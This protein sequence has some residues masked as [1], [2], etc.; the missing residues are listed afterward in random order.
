MFFDNIYAVITNQKMY[1]IIFYIGYLYY[2][3]IFNRK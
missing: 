3:K 1:N 2:T